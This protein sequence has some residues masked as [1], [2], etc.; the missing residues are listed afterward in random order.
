MSSV[1]LKAVV[2]TTI[3]RLG[4]DKLN[5]RLHVHLYTYARTCADGL[6]YR[7]NAKL[8]AYASS[9]GARAIA[10]LSHD[11]SKICN[12]I[13]LREFKTGLVQNLDSGLDS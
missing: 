10:C 8:N 4:Y 13:G 12:L 5:Y 6:Y 9:A 1:D 3:G 11:K 7:L 2:S